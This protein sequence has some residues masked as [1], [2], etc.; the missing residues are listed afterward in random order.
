MVVCPFLLKGSNSL[1]NSTRNYVKVRTHLGWFIM[2]FI[3]E[4]LHNEDLLLTT[5]YGKILNNQSQNQ[6]PK[7][8]L[9]L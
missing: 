6:L 5:R 9:N 1:E 4:E 8:Y 3:S 7:A 2:L